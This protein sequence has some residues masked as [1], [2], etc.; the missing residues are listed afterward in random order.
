MRIQLK[1]YTGLFICLFFFHQYSKATFIGDTTLTDVIKVIAVDKKCDSA[2]NFW[3]EYSKKCNKWNLTKKEIELIVK[4]RK[5]ITK[6]DFSYFYDVLPC[7]Y[8]GFVLING[9]KYRYEINAGSFM[10]LDKGGYYYYFNC[11]NKLTQKYFITKPASKKE[12]E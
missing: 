3:N 7:S 9:K 2:S 12:L 11:S 1:L 5:S 4:S 10:K 8:E 6:F